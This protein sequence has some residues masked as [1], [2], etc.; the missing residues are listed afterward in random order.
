[1]NCDGD[2]NLADYAAVNACLSGP[3]TPAPA[4]CTRAD[5]DADSDVDL[6][7]IRA[8]QNAFGG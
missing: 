1:M 8:I 6:A 7:D 4:N 2:V 3:V 5:A